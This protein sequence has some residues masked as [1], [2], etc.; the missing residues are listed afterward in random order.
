MNKIFSVFVV[1]ISILALTVSPVSASSSN[2]D[3][4][5]WVED[6]EVEIRENF[7]EL[8]IDKKLKIN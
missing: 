8:E 3:P 7:T 2:E 5:K 6:N 4:K 1:F